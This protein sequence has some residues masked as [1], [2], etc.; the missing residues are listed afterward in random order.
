MSR[1]V[2]TAGEVLAAAD[3]NSFLMDQSVM[4]FAGTAARGSAI[5]SPVEGMTSFL[6]DSNILSIYDGSNW[7]TSL[8]VTGG[9]LQVVSTTKTD[10]FT[11]SNSSFTEVTGL[12]ASITPRSTAS[13][14]L[15][16]VSVT[17]QRNLSN[18]A[19]G[20]FTIFKGSSNLISPDSP[21]SRIPSFSSGVQMG[22]TN[23]DVNMESYCFTIV[24]SPATTS[25]VTYAVRARNFGGL[26]VTYVNRSEGD[27]NLNSIPRGVSTITL[28]EVA[29]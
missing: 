11:L 18:A 23:G 17:G 1:K 10:T 26:E 5:P 29:G 12:T 19:V 21:G 6:E 24:D 16:N 27:G 9:I 3:V 4:S 2:F 25:S 22:D 14:I 20:Q 15:V 8:G 7:K 28:M 13:R